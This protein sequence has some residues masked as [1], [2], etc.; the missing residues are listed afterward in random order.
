MGA[1]S[2]I[3]IWSKEVWENPANNSKMDTEDFANALEEYNF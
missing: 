1:M 2:K 3:E